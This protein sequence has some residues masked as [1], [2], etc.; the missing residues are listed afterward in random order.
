MITY[1]PVDTLPKAE[2][3]RVLRNEC[4]EWMTKDTTEITAERQEAF[5]KNKIATGLIEGWVMF[6]DDDPIGYGLL[7]QSDDPQTLIMSCGLGAKYRDGGL[8]TSLVKMITRIAH[9]RGCKVQ[10]DV[11]SS[12]D[13]AKHVYAKCGYRVTGTEDRVVTMENP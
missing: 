11:L 8:G 4:A 3:L 10:L 6:S 13:R 9:V 12:N 1:V 2:T 5:F 7:L